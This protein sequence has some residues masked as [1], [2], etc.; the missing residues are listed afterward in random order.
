MNASESDLLPVHHWKSTDYFVERYTPARKTD[1]DAFVRTAKN[2]TFLFHRD[3]MD[4]HDDRFVDH[5]LLIFHG[6]TLMGLL[7]ANLA[8]DST[9]VSHAGLTYGGLM[10]PHA[11]T[12]LDVLHCFHALLRHLHSE[13]IHKL[14]YKRIPLFYNTLPDDEVAYALFLLEARLYRRDC[15]MV[16]PQKDRLR[17][18]R[19]RRREIRQATQLGVHVVQ[20]ATF[21]NF[22]EPVLALRLTERH[23]RRPVHSVEEITGLMQHFP[24]QIKQFSA[25]YGGQI[26]AGATIY[27]TPTV[28]HAQ[29]SAVSE[30]GSKIGALDFLF[31]WLIDERYRDKIYFDFGICNENEG[32]SLNLGLL[33]WK[34]GFGA[35]CYSHDFYEIAAENYVKLEPILKCRPEGPLA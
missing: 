27:E 20:E 5:S 33:D 31:G 13:G 26:V 21:L 30:M 19:R 29:Y 14:Q 3:Y 2:A 8:T 24:D 15:A 10:V 17:F 11:A 12:L 7:P 16:I 23:G 18:Q 25:Y 35:R 28:A 4:Y 34:E 22:W 6:K 1:W 32:L 9:L